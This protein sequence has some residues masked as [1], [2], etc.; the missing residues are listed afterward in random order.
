MDDEARATG[1]GPAPDRGPKRRAPAGPAVAVSAS[2]PRGARMAAD[3]RAGWMCPAR[4]MPRSTSAPTTAGS[5]WRA[6][7]ATASASST[8]S[9]ASS[10]SARA[11]PARACSARRRSCAPS[12]RLRVCRD[13][14]RNRG[15]TRSRLIATEACR[16][17]GNGLRIPRARP[18]RGRHRAGDRRPRDRG[19]ARRHR[20]HAA[21][22]SGGR[23][24]DPVRHRRR[25]V[26]TG[27]ARPLR[28]Q[29]GTARRIPRSTPGF[30]CRSASSR[31]PSATAA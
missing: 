18:Q 2:A 16:A 29:L 28:R 7:P 12:T 22:R 20:L 5:W 15:V 30:R 17:A 21:G 19:A 27:A 14:M 25:L 23:R 31:W 9:R 11:S 10:G 24:R 3:G 1:L 6:P 4:P 13:K 8:R 26:G